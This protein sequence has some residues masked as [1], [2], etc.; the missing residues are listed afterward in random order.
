MI[1]VV[2]ENN[3]AIIVSSTQGFSK[4]INMIPELRVIGLLRS[5]LGGSTSVKPDDPNRPR[6]GR[7]SG[8]KPDHGLYGLSETAILK[9]AS[10]AEVGDG[11]YD[12]SQ[13]PVCPGILRTV[14]VTQET[15]YPDTTSTITPQ[16]PHL[17]SNSAG[18]FYY[19]PG[20]AQTPTQPTWV[21]YIP[22]STQSGPA[23]RPYFV[24]G[25]ESEAYASKNHPSQRPPDDHVVDRPGD[26][27]KFCR[28]FIPT[29][30]AQGSRQT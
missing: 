11:V 22:A 7:G 6:T 20:E 12:V 28:K 27:C 1:C 3:V 9:S 17:Q 15:H 26:P 5:R 16:G 2:V 24:P 10:S 29:R 23:G 13:G 21:Y 18:V 4:F 25:Y 30:F 8:K 14:D 19:G